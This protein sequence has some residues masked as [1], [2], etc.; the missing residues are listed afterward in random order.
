MI[1]RCTGVRFL[2]C[3]DTASG[4]SLPVYTR[5][6]EMDEVDVRTRTSKNRMR[7]KTNLTHITRDSKLLKL[8]RCV[9][10]A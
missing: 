4:L 1:L 5:Q 7:K 10:D 3:F 8:L 2:M 9:V 6:R